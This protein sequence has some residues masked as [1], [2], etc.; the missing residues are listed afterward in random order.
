MRCQSVKSNEK[1]GVIHDLLFRVDPKHSK[2]QQNTAKHSKTQQ[3]KAF[4]STQTFK[5]RDSPQ[6]GKSKIKIKTL[7][8]KL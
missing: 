7:P 6:N 3:N 2:T 8:F 4:L 1:D 5:S